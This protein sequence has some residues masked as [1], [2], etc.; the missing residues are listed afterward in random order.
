MTQPVSA[1]MFWQSDSGL[2]SNPELVASHP[3]FWFGA[4]IE[5]DYLDIEEYNR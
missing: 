5:T 3:L 1:S 2:F 4:N